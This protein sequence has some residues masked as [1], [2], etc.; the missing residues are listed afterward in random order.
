MPRFK[1]ISEKQIGRP[2]SPYALHRGFQVQFAFGQVYVGAASVVAELSVGVDMGLPMHAGI[3]FLILVVYSD[4][5]KALFA[6]FPH[7]CLPP[8]PPALERIVNDMDT[9]SRV[10]FEVGAA[11]R[12]PHCVH[13]TK[14]GVRAPLAGLHFIGFAF[15]AH[16]GALFEIQLPCDHQGQCV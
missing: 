7:I 2:L 12:R 8:V 10:A 16:L 1:S 11:L 3:P 4:R 6:G 14:L 5:V 13:P 9:A 15:L